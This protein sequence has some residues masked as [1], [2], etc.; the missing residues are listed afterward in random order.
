MSSEGSACGHRGGQCKGIHVQHCSGYII[1]GWPPICHVYEGQESPIPSGM[2]IGGQAECV[3]ST[4]HSFIIQCSLQKTLWTPEQ[5][6]TP[7]LRQQRRA[8]PLHKYFLPSSITFAGRPTQVEETFIHPP[9]QGLMHST[10]CSAAAADLCLPGREAASCRHHKKRRS[11]PQ[12][13]WCTDA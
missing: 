12:N 2:Q 8:Y 10:G 4:L 13:C 1:P 5:N 3:D 6:G 11:F 9:F 7:D